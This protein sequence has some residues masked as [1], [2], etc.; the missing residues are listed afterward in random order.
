[1]AQGLEMATGG[2]LQLLLSVVFYLSLAL[3]STHN[4]GK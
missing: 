4:L 2:G 3:I 1:M